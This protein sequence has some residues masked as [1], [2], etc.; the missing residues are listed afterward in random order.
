M[1]RKIQTNIIIEILQSILRLFS[2]KQYES[3]RHTRVIDLQTHVYNLQYITF[4]DFFIF[5]RSFNFFSSSMKWFICN[6]LQYIFALK[7]MQT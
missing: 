4:N 5:M 1:L 2:F 7:I 3:M 6:E